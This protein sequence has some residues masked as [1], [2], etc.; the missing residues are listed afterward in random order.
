MSLGYEYA[1]DVWIT[2]ISTF[3]NEKRNKKGEK[4]VTVAERGRGGKDE[5]NNKSGKTWG[6]SPSINTNKTIAHRKAR[7]F[8]DSGSSK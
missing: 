8:Y 2:D 1:C 3:P 6:K 4:A 7:E 5:D